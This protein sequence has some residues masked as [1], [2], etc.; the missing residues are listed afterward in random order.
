MI[1]GKTGSGKTSLINGLIGKKVG[2]EGEGLDRM[3]AHVEAKELTCEGTLVKIWDT[4]GLQDGTDDEDR[5]LQEMKENCSDCNLYIYCLNMD[6]TRFEAAEIR[7]IQMLTETFGKNFWAKVLFVLTF[8]NKVETSCPMG[9]D[10]VTFFTDKMKEWH[11][12][13][14]HRLK[15]CGVKEEVADKIEVIPAGY[16][17]PFKGHPNPWKLPGIPNWFH[18]FWYKC[19]ETMDEKGIP[20][21]ITINI[22]RLKSPGEISKS[23]LTNCPIEEQPIPIGGQIVASGL[24]AFVGTTA[25]AGLGAGIGGGIGAVVGSLVGLIGGPAGVGAGIGIGVAAGSVIGTA[26]IDPILIAVYR[27]Y[28]RRQA[29]KAAKKQKEEAKKEGCEEEVC[30]KEDCQGETCKKEDCQEETCKKEDC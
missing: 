30:K 23:D 4:P 16:S 1:T 5:Y 8:A 19:A 15:E 26:V 24:L 20:A 29:K 9:S 3:T 11:A 2:E 6:Q 17:K 27:K 12:K 10:E 25:S 21:L 28:K 18:N 14:T 13:L 22:R 7:A